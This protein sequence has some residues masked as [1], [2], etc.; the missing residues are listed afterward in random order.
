MSAES[1]RQAKE[2]RFAV[3]ANKP[4]AKARDL[5]V[6]AGYGPQVAEFIQLCPGRPRAG[7]EPTWPV[8]MSCIALFA[9]NYAA[10][11]VLATQS[12]PVFPSL[13]HH[14]VDVILATWAVGRVM[15]RPVWPPLDWFAV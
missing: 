11:G 9:M 13:P 1:L 7:W 5:Q 12:S 4:R 14:A 3:A 6:A 2:E 10:S 8:V 15:T